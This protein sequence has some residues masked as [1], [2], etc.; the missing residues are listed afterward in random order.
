VYI[1]IPGPSGS[2]RAE[3][4][5]WLTLGG[6]IIGYSTAPEVIAC[7]H[8]KLRVMAIG[9]VLDSVVPNDSHEVPD[10]ECLRV[11]S[12]TAPKVVT[13]LRELFQYEQ[14]KSK[15]KFIQQGEGLVLHGN[16]YYHK[17]NYNKALDFYRHALEKEDYPPAI[18]NIHNRLS[19]TYSRLKDYHSALEQAE[20]MIKAK[21]DHPKGYL[22]RGG[23]YFFPRKIRTSHARLSKIK[24]SQRARKR[25]GH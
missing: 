1:A 5:A 25:R 17:Q 14:G 24:S 11:A 7:M 13:I 16:R 21:P 4:R 12:E 9:V 23:A 6:D 22:R 3:L 15:A 20:L 8:L 10:E 19:A 2:T 18:W